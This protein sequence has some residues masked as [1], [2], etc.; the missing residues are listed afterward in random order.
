[1]GLGLPLSRAFWNQK[2]TEG[3]TVEL[4]YDTRLI[5]V[6]LITMYFNHFMLA[7]LLMLYRISQTI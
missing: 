1:M 2:S 4:H 7:P 3:T 6:V 5:F